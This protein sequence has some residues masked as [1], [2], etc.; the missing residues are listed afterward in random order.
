MECC[1]CKKS[2]YVGKSEYSLNLRVNAHR[3]F[4]MR[5]DGPPRDKHFQNPGHNFNAHASFT[6]IEEVYN[7][8]LSTLKICSLLEHRKDFWILLL[9]NIT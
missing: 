1:L 4:V 9:Q 3:N 6:I 8:S 5:T 2:Q 7:K